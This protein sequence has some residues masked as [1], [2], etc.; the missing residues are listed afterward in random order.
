MLWSFCSSYY[1]L[2]IHMFLKEGK[3]AK[4]L[5][6][7][8]HIV[9][10]EL[11]ANSLGLASLGSKVLRSLTNLYGNPLNIVFPPDKTISLYRFALKLIST[12][13]KLLARSCT[14]AWINKKIHGTSS[15]I[16]DGL[17]KIYPAYFSLLRNSTSWPSG[18][19]YF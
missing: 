10:L 5:P 1:F 19:V 4:I 9:F 8:Q 15:P 2:V 6:P 16:L 18:S 17:N 3:L 11:G 7:S 14:T 12:L 13:E